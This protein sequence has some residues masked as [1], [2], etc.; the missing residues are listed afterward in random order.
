MLRQAL[1]AT[2]LPTHLRGRA[3]EVDLPV[4]FE[5]PD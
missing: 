5:L 2:P 4:L 1:P 3:F